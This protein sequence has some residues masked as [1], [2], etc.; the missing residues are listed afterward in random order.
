MLFLILI[1]QIFIGIRI[2]HTFV[3]FTGN[4]KL[5]HEIDLICIQLAHKKPLVTKQEPLQVSVYAFKPLCR[6]TF[7]APW[8]KH[9]NLIKMML[10]TDVTL[11]FLSAVNND[12][13]VYFLCYWCELCNQLNQQIFVIL[14]LRYSK[15]ISK[16]ASWETKVSCKCLSDEWNAVRE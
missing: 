2:W 10:A 16:N 14:V 3:D 13:L 9:Q 15:Q 8:V 6:T 12:I 11:L 1:G 5:V 7:K 4:I